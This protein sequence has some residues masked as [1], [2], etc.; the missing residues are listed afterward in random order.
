MSFDINGI[1]LCSPAK[2]L[3]FFCVSKISHDNSFPQWTGLKKNLQETIDFPIKYGKIWENL[4]ETID[5]PIECMGRVM[6]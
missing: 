6:I 4:Q 3:S 5:F 1:M 2:N